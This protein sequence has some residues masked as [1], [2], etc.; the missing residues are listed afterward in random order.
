MFINITIIIVIIIVRI[1]STIAMV[2]PSICCEA[3]DVY[4]ITLQELCTQ[5]LAVYCWGWV[6]LTFTHILHGCFTGIFHLYNK[7]FFKRSHVRDFKCMY[8]LETCYRTHLF[9]LLSFIHFKSSTMIYASYFIG[10]LVLKYIKG[11]MYLFSCCP[12]HAEKGCVIPVFLSHMFC[13]MYF[14]PCWGLCF[15][16]P[17]R[18]IL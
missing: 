8:V 4:S 6:G 13:L 7:W 1:A 18:T 16:N 5:H 3:V 2:S 12:F 15:T 10:H 9:R 11:M 14:T 17:N